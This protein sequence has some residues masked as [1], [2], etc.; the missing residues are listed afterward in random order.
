MQNK[1][2]TILGDRPPVSGRG[3]IIMRTVF[4]I[5]GVPRGKGRPRFSSKSGSVYT[6]EK[7]KAYEDLI[8][9][10]FDR[11]VGWSFLSEDPLRMQID[12]YYPIP[13]R[14][15]K[16][17]ADLMLSGRV[18]PTKKPDADNIAKI[19]CD[20]LN[21]IAYTDDSQIVDIQICKHYAKEAKTVVTLETMAVRDL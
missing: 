14:T 9:D 1:F 6:D 19:V 15:A 16:Y 20:A 2:V 10:S 12:A 11:Q 3:P 17:R 4:S 13:K 21:G 18:F 7:T 5:P 8:K